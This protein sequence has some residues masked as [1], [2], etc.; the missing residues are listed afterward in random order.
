MGRCSIERGRDGHAT[1]TGRS[2]SRHKNVRTAVN[3]DQ[4]QKIKYL[5]D[6]FVGEVTEFDAGL[7]AIGAFDFV[8]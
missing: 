8:F 5:V 3:F 2:R 7:C 1:V 4:F 6:V